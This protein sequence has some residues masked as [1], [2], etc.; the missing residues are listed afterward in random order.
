ML[1]QKNWIMMKNRRMTS[2]KTKSL[3]KKKYVESCKTIRETPQKNKKLHERENY[4]QQANI[5]MKLLCVQNSLSLQNF[6]FLQLHTSLYLTRRRLLTSSFARGSI[7]E[8][9]RQP[10]C[11][12]ETFRLHRMLAELPTSQKKK[13]KTLVLFS[14]ALKLR[15]WE[16]FF[17]FLSQH[18][19]A[20]ASEITAP[21][22][23]AA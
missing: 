14:L 3:T 21:T 9:D 18:L 23:K 2:K 19:I 5:M 7:T 11:R 16:F 22:A 20:D 1:A 10:A 15:S 17:S 8:W 12:C 6:T 4:V 13:K